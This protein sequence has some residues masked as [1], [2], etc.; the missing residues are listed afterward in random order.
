MQEPGTRGSRSTQQRA[1]R[2]GGEKAVGIGKRRCSVQPPRSLLG[3]STACSAP[4]RGPSRRGRLKAK[5]REVC[6]P[7]RRPHQ[8]AGS[9]IS[10]SLASP[11]PPEAS[12]SPVHRPPPPP[13]HS[14]LPIE[15]LVSAGARSS[16]GLQEQRK[17][18]CTTGAAADAGPQ[19][20]HTASALPPP[21]GACCGRQ[22]CSAPLL[23]ARRGLAAW[24]DCCRQGST[25]KVRLG[26]GRVMH[27]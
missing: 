2:H 20:R 26:E 5:R 18:G 27:R 1:G 3:P 10:R 12:A 6:R 22:G 15:L 4:R 24:R 8:L 13:L 25:S 11:P 9:R 23:V 21:F 14:P 17:H 16:A 7:G 19:R